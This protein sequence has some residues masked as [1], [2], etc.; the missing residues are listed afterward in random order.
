MVDRKVVGRE[1][2]PAVLALVAVACEQ[3][4]AIELHS[5]LGQAVVPQQPDDLGHGDVHPDRL[6]PVVPLGFELTLQLAD[7]DPALEVVVDVLAAARAVGVEI[8]VDDFR[9]VASEQTEG[10][11]GRHDPHRGVPAVEHQHLAVQARSFRT[12]DD[13]AAS[14]RQRARSVAAFGS[15]Q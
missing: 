13:A 12:A 10:T 6:D 3:V 11:L 14:Q 2:P 1:D 4:A 15:V 9:D 5:L 8:N 7:L